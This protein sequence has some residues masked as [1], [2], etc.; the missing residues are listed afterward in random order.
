MTDDTVLLALRLA[1]RWRNFRIFCKERTTCHGCPYFVSKVCSMKDDQKVIFA[2]AKAA[3][4]YLVK[5][6]ILI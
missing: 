3:E 6:G 5:E 1:V 2:I 4:K